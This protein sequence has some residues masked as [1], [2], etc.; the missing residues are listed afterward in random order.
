MKKLLLLVSLALFPGVVG[1]Q[2]VDCDMTPYYG[3]CPLC[4]AYHEANPE[5]QAAPRPESPTQ[6]AMA[7][8][9][10]DCDLLPYRNGICQVE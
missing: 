8:A 6:R 5:R 3:V 7:P 1:A 4:E 10:D 2:R 9:R